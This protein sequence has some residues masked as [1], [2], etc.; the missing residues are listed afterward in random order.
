MSNKKF[1]IDFDIDDRNYR[2][3]LEKMV[4]ETSRIG[5]KMAGSSGGMN[6]SSGDS[7]AF[8]QLRMKDM[9]REFNDNFSRARQELAKRRVDSGPFSGMAGAED[10]KIVQTASQFEQFNKNLQEGQKLQRFV[11]FEE[12]SRFREIRTL[13]SNQLEVDRTRLRREATKDEKAGNF[14]ASDSKRKEIAIIEK[15]LKDRKG[16]DGDSSTKALRQFGSHYFMNQMFSGMNALGKGGEYL[17]GGARTGMNAYSAAK[18]GGMSTAGAGLAGLVMAVVD[19]LINGMTAVFDTNKTALKMGGVVGRGGRGMQDNDY[20]SAFDNNGYKE[21]FESV[22]VGGRADVAQLAEAYAKSG[23]YGG[24]SNK[25][26]LEGAL[27]EKLIEKLT[28]ISNEQQQ[29]YAEGGHYGDRQ[30]TGGAILGFARMLESKNV[31]NIKLGLDS[32]GNLSERNLAQLPQ[33]LKRLVEI[34]EQM[35]KITGE[36]NK[37]QQDSSMRYFGSILGLGGIFKNQDVAS[38]TASGIRNAYANPTDALHQYK[39]VRAYRQATG[40]TGVVG[41]QE[42]LENMSDVRVVNQSMKNLLAEKGI[43][44][45]ITENGGYNEEGTIGDIM[46][47][48]GISSKTRARKFQN[49]YIEQGGLK[50]QDLNKFVDKDPTKALQSASESLTTNMDAFGSKIQATIEQWSKKFIDGVTGFIE[51]I[52][53]FGDYI[54]KFGTVINDMLNKIGLGSGGGR[55]IAP[56]PKNNNHAT[57]RGVSTPNRSYPAWLDYDPLNLF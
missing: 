17:A 35:F 36:R 13:S 1:V 48:F 43:K 10:H 38:E 9:Q 23:I 21:R 6:L 37:D 3:K 52:K 7:M 27:Q 19:P 57:K 39:N 49:Q 31:G 45:K 11:N 54:S 18:M 16:D 4:G 15:T 26:I 12:S 20:N 14:D 41:M 56:A 42:A 25:D 44:G 55:K 33:Y 53:T 32:Q 30:N 46:T 47:M 22:G 29:Q 28:G 8:Q 24:T 5:D 51:G 50:E 2:Q 34:N 40:K